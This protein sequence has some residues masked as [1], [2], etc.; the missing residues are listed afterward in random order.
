[1]GSAISSFIRTLIDEDIRRAIA[2]A[3]EDRVTL[4][5]PATAA[6]ILH[7]YPHCGMTERLIADRIM[8]AA[9]SAGLA[10]ELG[11]SRREELH[12]AAS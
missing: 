11:A 1:M 8:L 9:S 7:T 2:D 10:V 4:S 5:A 12:S 3:I 6:A